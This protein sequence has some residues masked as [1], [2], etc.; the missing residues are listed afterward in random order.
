MKTRQTVLH[1]LL[2][3]ALPLSTSYAQAKP[4]IQLKMIAGKPVVDG[5]FLD[6]HGPYRFLLD[7]GSQTNQVE[8]RLA[9]KLGLAATLELGFRTPAGTSLSRGGRVG[10]VNLGWME[11]LDQEFLFTSLDSPSI[12]PEGTQG[13]FG[14]EFLAHFDYTLDFQHHR[15][16]VGDLPAD[17]VPTKVRLI[18]GRMAV[19][20]S[21]G[22][23]V[24]DTGTETLF[25]F[26][27]PS[28]PATAQVT[29]ASGM[30]VPVSF[31]PAPK[32]RIGDRLYRPGNAVF[33]AVPNA[34]E[35]GL[36]PANI[37]HAIF[38]CNSRQYVVFDPSL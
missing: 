14:Q 8:S 7:T 32:L 16:I 27:E 21:L 10:K 38:I 5:V 34:E 18:F 11:A 13:I 28:R 6:G 37:F 2:F 17:G 31:E 24:L 30:R 29:S 23:L 33:H 35:A 19:S 22:E 3:A 25:L 12:W 15:L 20:T 9:S 26:R 1:V 4:S 36:L